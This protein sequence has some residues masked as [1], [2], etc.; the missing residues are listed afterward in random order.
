M[1]EDYGLAVGIARKL[2]VEAMPV[3]DVKHA[4]LIG[5]DLRV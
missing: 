1:Q 2:P 4:G 3:A 5:F